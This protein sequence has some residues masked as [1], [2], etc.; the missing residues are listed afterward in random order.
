MPY[1]VS[2]S[3]LVAAVLLC[4]SLFA[5]PIFGEDL[6]VSV[7]AKDS[8]KARVEPPGDVDEFAV[9]LFTGDVLKVKQKETGPIRDLKSTLFEA[10]KG[11]KTKSLADEIKKGR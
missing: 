6:P 11:F 3:A 1:S 9:R 4:S 7:G 2:R 5:A 8:I 10:P